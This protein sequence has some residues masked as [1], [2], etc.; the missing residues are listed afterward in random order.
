MCRQKK[1]LVYLGIKL[2]SK[3]LE[4]LYIKALMKNSIF[5]LF[6]LFFLGCINDSKEEGYDFGFSYGMTITPETPSIKSDSLFVE[7]NYSGC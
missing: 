4:Q 7:V 6:I 3:I 2:V 1:N 5:L